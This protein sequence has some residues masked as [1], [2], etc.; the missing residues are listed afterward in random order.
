MKKKVLKVLKDRLDKLDREINFL[1]SN[2]E[3]SSTQE[4]LNDAYLR[5][6]EVR[7]IMKDVESL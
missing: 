5:R 1:R 2:D 7:S 4:L 6:M 3:N